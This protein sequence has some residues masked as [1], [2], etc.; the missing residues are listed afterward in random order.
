MSLLDEHI[1]RRPAEMLL[2]PRDGE[3]AKPVVAFG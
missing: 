2:A 1:H 3:I